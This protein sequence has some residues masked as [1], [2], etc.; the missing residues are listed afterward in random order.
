MQWEVSCFAGRLEQ[1]EHD[2]GVGGDG[3]DD[4]CSQALRAMNQSFQT[5]FRLPFW[6]D[7]E[8]FAEDRDDFWDQVSSLLGWQSFLGQLKRLCFLV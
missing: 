1:T 4:A 6:W 3:G 7:T 8:L 2:V 5:I